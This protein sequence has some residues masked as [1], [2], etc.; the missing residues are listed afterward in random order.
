MN[1]PVR[2]G[3]SPIATTPTGFYSQ[4]CWDFTSPYW[5]LGLRGL[6]HSLV[7]PPGLS[8]SKCVTSCYASHFLTRS[9]IHHLATCPLSPSSPSLPLLPVWINVSSLIPWLSD[10]H[11][12][13][14]SGSSGYFL[15]LN[16]LLS[17]FWSCEEAKCV[18]LRLHLGRKSWEV[19]S[20]SFRVG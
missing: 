5:K 2:L 20:R 13:R 8:T 6:S 9:S 18:Y 4:R 7:V 11:T 16:L 14:F 17:F 3:V 1:S 12:V 19:P 10:F 15:F